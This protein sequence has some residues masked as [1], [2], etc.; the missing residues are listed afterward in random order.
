MCDQTGHS[1][2]KTVYS[3]VTRLTD[4]VSDLLQHPDSEI[5]DGHGPALRAI[6]AENPDTSTTT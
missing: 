2:C 6:M 5:P 4:A 3:Y 1:V